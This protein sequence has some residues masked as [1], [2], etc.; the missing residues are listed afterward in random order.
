V[1]FPR[2]WA[3]ALVAPVALVALVAACSDDGT[4]AVLT[5]PGAV[6]EGGSIPIGGPEAGQTVP[7]DTYERVDGGEA[8]LAEYRGRPLVVNVWAS[9]C[10][11]C[12]QEMP[13]FE[14]VHQELGD[15][16]AFV[17][18]NSSDERAAARRTAGATGV[19]YD[20]LFDPTASFVAATGVVAYPS[21][22][23][24]DPGGRVVAAQAGALSADELRTKLQELF[25]T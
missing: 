19:T 11:P 25:G 9:W 7:A 1:R 16:V 17:G 15:E 6:Q 2:R 3:A 24:V 10:A 14:A 13:D 21:T 8:T 20:L 5:N 12:K 22:V 23:F 4:D 18:M